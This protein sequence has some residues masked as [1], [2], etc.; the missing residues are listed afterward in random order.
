MGGS[1]VL[2]VFVVF[3]SRF[4]VAVGP[5]RKKKEN[6]IG[7]PRRMFKK[8]RLPLRAFCCR[9]SSQM[10]DIINNFK[11]RLNSKKRSK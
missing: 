10:T 4:S 3:L 11:C 8:M 1:Y 5:E 6:I 9:G 2:F 7:D